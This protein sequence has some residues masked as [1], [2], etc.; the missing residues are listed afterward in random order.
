MSVQPTDHSRKR[1]GL[2]AGSSFPFFGFLYA[3]LFGAFGTESPFFP[4]FLAMRGLSASEIG[5]VLAA[6]TL[7]RIVSGPLV[8]MAADLFGTRRI[9]ALAAALAG[10]IILLY[11]AGT[12]FWSLLLV[13][14]LH[15][16]AITPLN[17]LA[18]A[19]ALPASVREGVFPYGWVRGVGSASFVFGRRLLMRISCDVVIRLSRSKATRPAGASITRTRRRSCGS[20]VLSTRPSA[21]MR[22][23]IFVSVVGSK[24]ACAASS[25]MGSASRTANASSTRNC[26]IGIRS[27]RRRSCSSSSSCLFALAIR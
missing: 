16:V 19:L 25:P 5:S 9:L 6:G 8:G 2:L 10:A 26:S 14:M 22:S 18:D 15:S 7:V 27:S 13:C 17:P 20:A 12:S 4:S 11:L 23:I 3:A 21:I 1:L 24:S